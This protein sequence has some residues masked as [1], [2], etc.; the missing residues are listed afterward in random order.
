MNHFTAAAKPHSLQPGRT[1]SGLILLALVLGCGEDKPTASNDPPDDGTLRFEHFSVADGETRRYP[2]GTTV[3]SRMGVT[4]DGN[5]VIEGT[6]AGDFRIVSEK[7]IVSVAGTI[8]VASAAAPSAATPGTLLRRRAAPSGGSPAGPAELPKGTSVVIEAQGQSRATIV[9]GP[10][11][12]LRS[13]DGR[14]A[15]DEVVATGGGRIEAT[16]G[17]DAGDIIVTAF[18][19][20][21]ELPSGRGPESS[22]VFHLGEG[23]RGAEIS[24]DRE[25]Y[26]T[27]ESSIELV[28]GRGG[29]SGRLV[30]EAGQIINR[31][32]GTDDAGDLMAGGEGGRGGHAVWD[33]FMTGLLSGSS[34][35]V[36][37]RYTLAQIVLQ[38]GRGGDG[39]LLGGSGGHAFY[40][41]LRVMNERGD[42]IASA[43]VYGGDGGDV[44]PSPVP[45]GLVIGGDGGAYAALGNN[46]WSGAP[47]DSTG[48]RTGADGGAALARGGDGGNVLEGVTCHAAIG[49]DGGNTV[50]DRTRI[51]EDLSFNFPLE[52][53]DA[54]FSVQGGYGGRGTSRC[55]GCP[56]GAGG[57]AGMSSVIGGDGGSVLAAAV[58]SVGGCGGDVWSTGGESR[59]GFGGDG[60]PPG[61]GG[62][63]AA[64][65]VVPGE[66]GSA[67]TPGDP[68]EVLRTPRASQDGPDGLICGEQ[69]GECDD[70]SDDECDPCQ[71]PFTVTSV[72]VQTT[73]QFTRTHD[74]SANGEVVLNSGWRFTG[75]TYRMVLD[76]HDPAF[77][78]DTMMTRALTESEAVS[79]VS[80]ASGPNCQ[81]GYV[82]W[83]DRGGILIESAGTRT[84][85]VISGCTPIFYDC[86]AREEY[87]CCPFGSG[88]RPCR[89]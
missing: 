83:A 14:D 10:G 21:I 50:L 53:F 63:G 29:Q 70:D 84:T 88:W 32:L 87:I 68:G 48:P 71:G 42:P 43:N 28:A 59:S 40:F 25:S 73:S 38:G 30:L 76:V 22:P 65:T 34:N 36:D 37:A 89:P 82:Q 78:R 72:S 49:G 23:G 75:G 61:Q 69:A 51:L 86:D 8:L 79:L 16:S 7:G 74:Y 4:I 33:N 52:Q 62:A 1:R 19:G 58:R 5:I 66:G 80:A 12:F 46:G 20:T 26:R 3:V 9:F 27:T 57:R 15:L 64:P 55:D 45:A 35:F 56:G 6:G 39:A 54:V 31:P 13:G 85:Y 47:P 2:P 17:S 18:G 77:G 67:L 81:M 24:V 11:A 44:F 60:N 41:G